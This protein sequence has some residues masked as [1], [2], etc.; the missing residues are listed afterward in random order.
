[1]H[2]YNTLMAVV[3]GL[4]H[5][6]ISRLKDTTSHVHNEVT[7]VNDPRPEEE[8][9]E[10]TPR[11]TSLMG[12]RLSLSLSPQVLN[13]MTDLLSSCRNYDNYRQAYN[14]C[15]GFKIPILGVHLKDL[16]S[17]NEAMSDYV[18]DGKVNVQ[19]LQALYSHINELIQLQQI[20]PRL[21][22]NKDLV[23]LLTVVCLSVGT[24]ALSFFAFPAAFFCVTH[25]TASEA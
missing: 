17:V 16:I 13:E 11:R 8:E 23:H 14:R 19:K 2:N 15:T 5:S 12:S 7:K 1:M 20:P 21:D 4:C 10:A 3:G 24:F 6:S 9:E 25:E 18:E 22:A